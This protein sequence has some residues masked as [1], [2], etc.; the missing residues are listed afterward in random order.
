MPDSLQEFSVQTSNY[1]AQFGQNSGAIV[2]V[3]TKSGSNQ[4]H[5]GA[6]EFVRNSVFNARNWAAPSR[7]QIKRNQFG[8]TLGGPV[9]I[10]RLYNGKD[11]TFFFFGEQSTRFRYVSSS[12]QSFVPTPANLTGNF[13][14]YLSAGNP[15]NPLGRSISITD[16]LTRQPFP[17]NVIPASRFDPAAVA[18]AKLLPSATTA[19]G[20]T[21]FTS[22]FAPQDF[23][24]ETVRID[25]AFSS[26]DRLMGRYFLDT[27]NN[28]AIYTPGNILVYHD[29]QP[30]H[31]QNLVVQEFHI[32]SPSIINDARFS[33]SRVNGQQIPP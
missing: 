31:S 21:L 19:S 22:P 20:L 24:E 9:W 8:G 3:V 4:F 7:D 32:F 17:G 6:F 10:P 1:S 26:N 15:A 2:N 29:G 5:G 12:G 33:F 14:A 30:N 27:F 25:H 28:P 11:R 18:T 16:P 13:S 23:D